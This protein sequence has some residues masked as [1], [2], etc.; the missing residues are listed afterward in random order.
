MPN[1][2]LCAKGIV[3]MMRT[4]C[5]FVDTGIPACYETSG[6]RLQK[7]EVEGEQEADLGTSAS[8]VRGVQ[9]PG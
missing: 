7:K 5:R 9:R 6:S 4:G 8:Q 1:V 2:F 3:Q